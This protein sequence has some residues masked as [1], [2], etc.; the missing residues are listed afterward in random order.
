MLVK[1][2]STPIEMPEQVEIMREI[3]NENLDMLATIPLAIRTY[4]EQ[5]EWWIENKH[6]I[7]AYL[8]EPLDCLGNH[9][10]FS[11]LTDRGGFYTPIIAIRKECWGKGYGKEIISDYITKAQG[12]LAGSQLESNKAICHMNEKVGWQI[13]G[14]VKNNDT[15]IDLLFHPGI[16]LCINNQD[17]IIIKIKNYLFCKYK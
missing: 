11:M 5:Q 17:A 14:K 4:D 8:Y 3:F 10:A 7:K 15:V 13:V 12:P 16:N 6:C 9:M 2:K 1:L